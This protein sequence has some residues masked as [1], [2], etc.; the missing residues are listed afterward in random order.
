MVESPLSWLQEMQKVA[1]SPFAGWDLCVTTSHLGTKA[2]QRSENSGHQ[3]PLLLSAAWGRG[4]GKSAPF[5]STYCVPGS[6]T[7]ELSRRS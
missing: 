6:V 5:W 1:G 7:E 2:S 4:K 3:K